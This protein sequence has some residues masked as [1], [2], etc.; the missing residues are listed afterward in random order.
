[1]SNESAENIEHDDQRDEDSQTDTEPKEC[2]AHYRLEA[3]GYD[4]CVCR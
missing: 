4:R 3:T 2:L 1:M